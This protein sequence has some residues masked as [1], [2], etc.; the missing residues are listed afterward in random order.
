MAPPPNMP[1]RADHEVHWGLQPLAPPTQAQEGLP[2]HGPGSYCVPMSLTSVHGESCC[3]PDPD[4]ERL[5]E[6]NRADR[7]LG[8][9]YQ[10]GAVGW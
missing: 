3:R 5:A 6:W 1:T 2:S 4:F 8:W 10:T 9:L 7:L